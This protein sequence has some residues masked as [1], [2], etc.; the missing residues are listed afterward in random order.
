M[1]IEWHGQNSLQ[2]TNNKY[3]EINTP[4]SKVRGANMGPTW[5]GQDPL[6]PMLA[7]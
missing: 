2:K 5:G 1:N 4:D 3:S 6:G 7:P